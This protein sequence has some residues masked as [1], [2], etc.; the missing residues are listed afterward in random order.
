MY[1]F[2][3][4]SLDSDRQSS[5]EIRNGKKVL[6]NSLGLKYAKRTIPF[7]SE[8]L[9]RRYS[10]PKFMMGLFKEVNNGKRNSSDDDYQI[11]KKYMHDSKVD[12][13]ISFFKYGKTY[14]CITSAFHSLFS[15]LV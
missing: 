12:T 15:P 7:Q 1:R 2:S 8:F 9:L 10:A 14:L 13:V 5:Q 6:M 11:E 4:A 3:I